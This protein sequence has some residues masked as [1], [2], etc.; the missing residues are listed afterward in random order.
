[1]NDVVLNTNAVHVGLLVAHMHQTASP[2]VMPAG[3]D[4]DSF[5][6]GSHTH[7]GRWDLTGTEARVK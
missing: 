1:M 5:A 7:W 3:R 2:Q 6:A 4:L